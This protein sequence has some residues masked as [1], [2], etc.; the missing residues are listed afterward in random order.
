MRGSA[1]TTLRVATLSDL[2]SIDELVAAAFQRHVTNMGFPPV[3]LL[4]DTS[5]QIEAGEIWVYGD[6]ITGVMSVSEVGDSLVIENMAVHPAVQ[7]TGIGRRLIEHA[8]QMATDWRLR[9]VVLVR[10]AP[11]V[12]HRDFYAHV[13]Y[14]EADRRTGHGSR[15]VFMEKSLS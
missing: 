5:D 11:M 4:R 1:L 12:T 3:Q 2:E 6:P 7:G 8:E 9:R 13:G 14:V 10:N 15:Q